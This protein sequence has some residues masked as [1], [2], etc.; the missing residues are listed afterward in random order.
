MISPRVNDAR[1]SSYPAKLDHLICASG[2]G[3]YLG[4]MKKKFFLGACLVA[5]ASS[6]AMAQVGVAETVVVTVE[7]NVGLHVVISRGPGKSEVVEVSYKEIRQNP[8]AQEERLQQVFD[9]LFQQ[10]FSLQGTYGGGGAGRSG[11]FLFN[12]TLIFTKRQ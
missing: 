7:N 4:A 9:K 1:D 8:A 2:T 10:G 6:P 3:V 11:S 5:L 12:N